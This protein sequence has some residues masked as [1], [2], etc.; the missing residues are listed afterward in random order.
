MVDLFQTFK[1]MEYG[2]RALRLPN[3]TESPTQ[4]TF[5]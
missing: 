3:S 5:S 2:L 1:H 4:S